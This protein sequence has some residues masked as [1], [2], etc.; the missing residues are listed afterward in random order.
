MLGLPIPAIRAFGAAA[1]VAI[2]ASGHGR[3]ISYA[4]VDA[5]LGEPDT[6]LRLFGKPEVTGKRRVGVALALGEDVDAA[7]ARARRVAESV[8]IDVKP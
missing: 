1:S 8:R 5:A 6:G 4:G 3:T 2:L 7:R